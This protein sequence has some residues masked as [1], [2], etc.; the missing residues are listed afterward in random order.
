[1]ASDLKRAEPSSKASDRVSPGE[2]DLVA[3]WTFEE[4]SG[5]L[6]K[7]ATANKHHLHIQKPPQWRVKCASAR[8]LQLCCPTMHFSIQ[9][10]V[11]DT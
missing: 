2:A 3:Y 8:V 11:C 4:G 10:L 7:D 9:A 1:M 5:Y 6:V